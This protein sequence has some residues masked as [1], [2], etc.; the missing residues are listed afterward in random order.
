MIEY[1]SVMIFILSTTLAFVCATFC[2]QVVSADPGVIVAVLDTGVDHTH[3]DL[4]GRLVPGI[5]LV[6]DAQDRNGHGTHVAGII[7][8]HSDAMIMPV[9]VWDLGTYDWSTG[10]IEIVAQG[11]VWAVQNGAS[12]IN[13]SGDGNDHPALAEAVAYAR[14][15]GVIVVASTG[16]VPSGQDVYPACYG[17]VVGVGALASNGQR[18]DFS[19]WV[20][21]DRWEV[22]IDVWSTTPTSDFFLA[23]LGVT[24]VY[25]QMSGT[26]MAT[27]LVSASMVRYARSR[28]PLADSVPAPIVTATPTPHHATGNGFAFI[29]R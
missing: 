26:S 6:G 5:S 14:R 18:A 17:G 21:V 22:G 3:P 12:I 28:M 15:H 9:K 19:N 16:N 11:I 25:A 10:R 4:A 29:Q 2:A 27:A 23:K 1:K 13:Y 7:A 20:C 8:L 24:P